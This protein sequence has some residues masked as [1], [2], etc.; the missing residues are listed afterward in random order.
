CTRASY[1][2]YTTLFRSR[3]TCSARSPKCMLHGVTEDQVFTTAI[4]GRAKSSS[5]SP[6]ARKYERAAARLA[7]AVTTALRSAFGP[8]EEESCV[9]SVRFGGPRATKNP[10]PV[11]SGC[12]GRS[13]FGW[14]GSAQPRRF[15]AKNKHRK[16]KEQAYDRY[17]HARVH[18]DGGRDRT[19]G[20]ALVDNHLC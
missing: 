2:T 9:I 14:S 13:W 15:G 20:E 16:A 12:C 6:A 3:R 18:R 7:P 10:L 19:G 8:L 4:S 1:T 17:E 11:G 5:P